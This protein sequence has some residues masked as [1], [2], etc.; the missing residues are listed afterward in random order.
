M[1]TPRIRKQE[2]EGKRAAYITKGGEEV[3]LIAVDFYSRELP[4]YVENQKRNPQTGELPDEEP[5]F[6][7]PSCG[8]HKLDDKGIGGPNSQRVYSCPGCSLSWVRQEN[9]LNGVG[10]EMQ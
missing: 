1:S 3:P 2:T 10:L 6:Y 9:M 4:L 8:N 5:K 7:C